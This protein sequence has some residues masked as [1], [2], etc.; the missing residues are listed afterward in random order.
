MTQPVFL[1]SKDAPYCLVIIACIKIAFFLDRE[2]SLNFETEEILVS[3]RDFL[4]SL[5]MIVTFGP[6]LCIFV[7]E[8]KIN[9]TKN[10][11]LLNT[12]MNFIL[13]GSLF[14]YKVFSAEIDDT[15]IEGRT[16]VHQ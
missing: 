7:L 11:G 9:L 5:P 6:F 1:R 3:Y 15:G 4:Y 14:L 8:T 16:S 10:L 12:G 13:T 2:R